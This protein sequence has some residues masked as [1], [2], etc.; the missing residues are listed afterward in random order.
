MKSPEAD[1]HTSVLLPRVK[2]RKMCLC[3]VELQPS[4]VEVKPIIRSFCSRSLFYAVRFMHSTF[5]SSFIHSAI[6]EYLFCGRSCAVL[7]G[8]S[9]EN[10]RNNQPP[11]LAH[12]PHW[13]LRLQKVNQTWALEPPIACNHHYTLTFHLL[14]YFL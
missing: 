7:S 9:G 6:V 14:H 8:L 2:T 12:P 4:L 5:N 1:F 3:T 10:T 13:V 11:S